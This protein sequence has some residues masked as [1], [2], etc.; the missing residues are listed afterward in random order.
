MTSFLLVSATGAFAQTTTIG[1]DQ[2]LT[3]AGNPYSGIRVTNGAAL[4]GEGLVITQSSNNA[5]LTLT[6]GSARL[7]GGSITQSG[8]AK[9]VSGVSV[10]SGQATLSGTAISIDGA[11]DAGGLYTNGSGA[12]II[13]DNLNITL[14]AT[15]STTAEPAAGVKVR[16]GTIRT[17]NSTIQVEGDAVL[18]LLASGNRQQSRAF[19]T[20]DT[21]TTTGDRAWGAFAF[22]DAAGVGAGTIDIEGGSITTSGQNAYGLLAQG[23]NSRIDASGTSIE[24]RGAGALGAYAYQGDINLAN[25]SISTEGTNASGIL[26]YLGDVVMDGGSVSTSGA[27]AAAVE[28]EGGSVTIRNAQLSSA[29]GSGV[30]L[31]NGGNVDL[32]S[33][34]ISSAGS[35]FVAS[36][37]S[38]AQANIVLGDGAVATQNDGT[39]LR[40]D[41]AGNGAEGV[42]DLTLGAG[43]ITRGDIL[44]EGE[45]SAN[46]GTDV[47]L[48]EGA[49]FAGILRGVRNFFS[50]PGGT[51][52]FEGETLIEGNLSGNGTDYT[53]SDQG[54]QIG[55]NVTLANGSSTIG[56]TVENRINVAGN[57]SVDS[58]SRMGGNWYINGDLGSAG[59]LAP[60]NSPGVISVAGNLVLSPTSIYEVE[61]DALGNSDL[62]EVGGTATLNGEVRVTPLGGF[63]LNSPYTILTAGSLNGTQFTGVTFSDDYAFIDA[64][65]DYDANNVLLTIERND[66]SFVS[67]A[68]TSNQSAT[69]SALDGL[70]SSSRLASAL[71]LSSVEEVRGAL[72]QL[73]GEVHASVKTGL[74]E[75]SRHVRDAALR[76]VQGAFVENDTTASIATG[77]AGATGFNNTGVWGQVYG[78]WGENDRNANTGRLERDVGGFLV[79]ADGMITDRVHLGILAGYSHS[80]FE[81]DDRA[82][83]AEADS[84]HVGIYG[85]TRISGF[86]IKAGAAYSWNDVETQRAVAFGGFADT[87]PADYDAGTTQVFGEVGYEIVTGRATFEPF[88]GIAYVNVDTDG[89]TEDGGA[90]ALSSAD[91]DTDVTFSTLGLRASTDFLWGEQQVTGR[92]M[93]G[94]RHAFDDQP[95]TSLAFAGTGAFTI[96]GAPLSENAAVVEVGLDFAVSSATALGITY[97]GQFGDESSDNQL[98]ADFSYKF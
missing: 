96:D 65:L 24:T 9:Y 78:S 28:L 23:A 81:L 36:F 58:S 71:A 30:V 59:I 88:A 34:T 7:S 79:G 37:D 73:S 42:V 4:Q 19:S 74:I 92:G 86:G 21:I 63:V 98:K 97:T 61:I 82:S 8:T 3:S 89:F 13:G 50:A 53:F 70:A 83:S 1:T 62:I 31:T 27:G 51:V 35:T 14:R 45:K 49:D 93:I 46:G 66:V 38:A 39:L 47:R 29:A 94:W 76:R 43:S 91:Q 12:E 90:A 17:S 15:G 87:L 11:K 33:S 57:V 48:E 80:E 68:E 52:D 16:S 2:T 95:S 85:G 18:G 69:A 84:V 72:D 60:G 10:V 77:S 75:E 26:S 22:S 56:G 54:A 41:R 55:G 44:D 6:E 64:T 5:G 40:V 25:V 67:A 32:S 20:N